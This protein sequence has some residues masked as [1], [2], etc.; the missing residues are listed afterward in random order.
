MQFVFADIFLTLFIFARLGPAI[1]LIS[2]IGEGFVSKPIRLYISLMLSLVL[3]F[4]LKDVI[5]AIPATDTLLGVLL[6]KEICIGFFIGTLVHLLFYTLEM[7]GAL[8]SFQMGC[9]L[10]MYLIR[11][12]AGKRAL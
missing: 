7:A 10:P 4:P 2:G 6:F 9:P 11:P 3:S 5:P 8:L 12:L 1:S